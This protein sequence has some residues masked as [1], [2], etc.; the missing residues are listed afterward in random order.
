MDKRTIFLYTVFG[1][2]VYFL[3]Q[4]WQKDYPPV[5]SISGNTAPMMN[6]SQQLPSVEPVETGAP[7]DESVSLAPSP[8]TN[9]TQWV[10]VKTD[11]LDIHI[12]LNQ[13]SIVQADLLNYP[14]SMED[15]KPIQILSMSPNTSFIAKTQLAQRIDN[16][17]NVNSVVYQT[18]QSSYELMQAQ[19][20]LTVRLQGKDS[21]GLFITKTFHFKQGSY[22]V[23][24]EDEFINQGTKPWS[25]YF[26]T[27]LVQNNP[28]T[29]ASGMFQVG[30]YRG[31]SYSNPGVSKYKKVSYQ[32]MTKR[33]LDV[34][35]K[36]GWIAMQQHYFV[37]SL[38]PPAQS[39]HRFYTSFDGHQYTI[40]TLSSLINVPAGHSSSIH[41][42]LYVG[43]ED[44]A[45]LKEISPGLDLT[46]DYGWFW[47]FSSILFSIMKNIH[48][49]IGNWGWSI[50]LITL[51]IKVVFYRLAASGYR[52]MAGMRQLQPKIQALKDRY[53]DDKAKMSQA[54]MELYRNEKINPM[55]GCLPFLIQIPIL[56]GLYSVLVESVELRHAPFML[57][58]NDLAAPDAFHVLPILMGL[59][60]FV[61]QKLNPTPPDPMQA[62]MMMFFPLISVVFMWGLPSGLTLYWTVNNI[63][64]I[65]QQWWI[66]K[67]YEA[68][69][70]NKKRS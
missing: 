9:Q 20:D 28:E 32:D 49:L 55:G 59:S 48:N 36:G 30:I 14:Q 29:Q 5:T 26:N 69:T 11:V 12:D 1:F 27:Q 10:H 6:S 21:S 44:T 58:I 61:Q 64:S 70:S 45:V 52:S 4:A 54:T 31:A 8:L 57:W 51:L 35:V 25:G 60:I 40:G 42:Q 24:I 23:Q 65:V 41:H 19:T 46:V 18:E 33:N 16:Q 17:L 66:M 63:L 67:Q 56:Y 3:I 7:H 43:P 62:K 2:I 53:G 22:L 34:E 50:I 37:T 68:K 38:I 13:G 47:F 15:K 39:N